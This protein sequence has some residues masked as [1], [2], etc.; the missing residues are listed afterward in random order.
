MVAQVVPAEVGRQRQGAVRVVDQPRDGDGGAVEGESAAGDR[1]E[2]ALDQAGDPV[3]DLAGR[4]AALVLCQDVLVAHLSGEVHHA[5]GDVVHVDVQ[6]EAGRAVPA[7]AS[8]V[9][10]RPGPTGRWLPARG[11]ARRR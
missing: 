9:G 2:R 4:V 7:S 8:A 10:G 3:E 1:V 11:P 5:C 6:A